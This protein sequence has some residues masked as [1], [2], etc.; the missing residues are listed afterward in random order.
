MFLQRTCCNTFFKLYNR[1]STNCHL[2]ICLC[3]SDLYFNNMYPVSFWDVEINCDWFISFLWVSGHISGS[4][5]PTTWKVSKYGFFRG[6]FCSVFSYI[7]TEYGDLST[8][9]LSG[10]SAYDTSMTG[11]SFF[12]KKGDESFSCSLT[13]L[14][15]VGR[16]FLF[17]LIV[18]L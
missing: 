11:L 5:C 9:F 4:S 18:P 8:A 2:D 15:S 10:F 3:G 13:V 17:L 1:F 7:R 16:P 12:Q 14:I 6:F